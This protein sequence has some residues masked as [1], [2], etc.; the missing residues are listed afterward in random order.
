VHHKLDLLGIGA[1]HTKDPNGIAWKQNQD[2]E[3]LLKRLNENSE[4]PAEDG[5]DPVP[6]DG[7]RRTQVDDPAAG[8]VGTGPETEG[9]DEGGKVK[10]RKS[11]KKRLRDDCETSKMEERKSKKRKQVESTSTAPTSKPVEEGPSSPNSP[12]LKTVPF[13]TISPFHKMR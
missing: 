10:K 7:F 9:G 5:V 6:I 4:D 11:K 8:P 1:Q 12:T 2:F 3:N 13:V